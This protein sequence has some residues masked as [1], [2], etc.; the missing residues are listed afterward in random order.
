MNLDWILDDIT[1]CGD[2][3]HCSIIKCF[4][5]FSNRRPQPSPD[6][7]SIAF[8]QKTPDCPYYESEKEK[9]NDF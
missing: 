6:V 5:H 8:F 3:E 7:Y 4:R 2:S 1:W 9:K